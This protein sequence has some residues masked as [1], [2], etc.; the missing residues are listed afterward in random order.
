MYHGSGMGNFLSLIEFVLLTETCAGAHIYCHVCVC[1]YIC[2]C[3]HFPLFVSDAS[4]HG[5]LTP[6]WKMCAILFNYVTIV[7]DREFF[8]VKVQC[9]PEVEFDVLC[10]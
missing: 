1:V 8:R 10:T 3:F 7:H 9:Y 2:L 4:C 6:C 5:I